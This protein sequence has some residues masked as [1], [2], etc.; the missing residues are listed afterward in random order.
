MF[1]FLKRPKHEPPARWEYRWFGEKLTR[2]QPERVER[3]EKALHNLGDEGWE[4]VGM[5]TA[6]KE[7]RILFK[8]RVS[9]G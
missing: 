2:S 9:N 8:R 7:L 3:S 4:A 6:E 5:A 1:D